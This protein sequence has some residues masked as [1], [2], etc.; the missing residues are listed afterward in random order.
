MGLYL[1]EAAL[2]IRGVEDPKVGEKGIGGISVEEATYRSKLLGI[3]AGKASSLQRA[4]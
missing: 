3:P 4:A 1:S 2:M